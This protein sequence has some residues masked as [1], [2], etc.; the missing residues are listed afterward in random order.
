[1][2]KMK[3]LFFASL[4]FFAG[5]SLLP[6]DFDNVEFD[7]LASL[8]VLSI[9]PYVNDDWCRQAELKRMKYVSDILQ[10]Y[11]QNRLNDNISNIYAEIG[12]LVNELNEREKPSSAYCQLK[13]KNIHKATTSALEVFGGRK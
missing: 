8:N 12:S 5:C 7:R 9:S 1:M 13:R 6:S 10:V 2:A 3:Q 11:S 4:L